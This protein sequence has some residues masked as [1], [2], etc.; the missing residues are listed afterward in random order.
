MVRP[1][2]EEHAIEYTNLLANEDVAEAYGVVGLP[3]TFILD[4]N[5]NI[6]KQFVGPK[7]KKVLEYRLQRAGEYGGKYE[8]LSPIKPDERAYREVPTETAA[9]GVVTHQAR[10]AGELPAGA[11][12]GGK[13]PFEHR[14][15]GSAL[16]QHL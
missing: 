3:A 1:F 6:V 8:D 13:A 5:G 12:P 16:P 15:R 11:R 10:D 7:P 9:S 14:L 2:I 4:R